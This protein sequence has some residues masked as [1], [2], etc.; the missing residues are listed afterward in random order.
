MKKYLIVFILLLGFMF[1]PNAY[2]AEIPREGVTYF[3]EY[4]DGTEEVTESYDEAI[5]TAEEEKLIFTGQTDEN[6]QV[7]LENVASEGTIRVVQ[8]VPNGYS[9]DE[10]EVIINLQESKKVEFKITQ[11]LINP[12]TG[13]YILIIIFA[14]ALLSIIT[15]LVKKKKKTLLVLPLLLL[16]GLVKVNA[17]SDNLV[18]DVKDNL[19]RAQSGVTVKI[20]AKPTIDASPAI[21]F[22]ANGGHFFDGKT[23]M[24][25]RIP[26]NGCNYDDWINTLDEES[27]NYLYGNSYGIYRNGYYP[28]HP[29]IP[30]TFTN[31]TLIQA[32]WTQDSE[33][34]LITFNL[35]GKQ[36]NFYGTL[37][38]KVYVYNYRMVGIYIAQEALI[39]VEEK[40]NEYM[41]GYDTT[42]SCNNYNS[43]GIANDVLSGISIGETNELYMC[44]HNKP[45]GIYVNNYAYI[46]TPDNCFYGQNIGPYTTNLYGNSHYMTILANIYNDDNSNP[47]YVMLRR[48]KSIYSSETT[49]EQEFQLAT[50]LD[51]IYHG[52][53]IISMNSN[54]FTTTQIE[55]ESCSPNDKICNSPPH[56]VNVSSFANQTKLNQLREYFDRAVCAQPAFPDPGPI[57]YE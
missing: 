57:Y 55:V 27:Y 12:K 32:E 16:V 41:I 19:G 5:A 42:V 49:S 8:E 14:V 26:S 18:I 37:M 4:P 20:Y 24:Y 50:S 9:T 23:L 54:D 39:Q 51:V 13:Q 22:D 48:A 11:G 45:D 1:M 47:P 46:A 10:R 31:G 52:E 38:D 33:A 28:Y 21:K 35:N 2:A 43:Y 17:D 53:T 44:W 30:D 15:V 36:M 56:N 25:A 40:Y 7:V 29:E 3:L 6:G 34:E